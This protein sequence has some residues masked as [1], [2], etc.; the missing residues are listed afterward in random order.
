ML[1]CLLRFCHIKCQFFILI[2]FYASSQRQ[3]ILPHII[4]PLLT[5][6]FSQSIAKYLYLFLSETF[7]ILNFIIVSSCPTEMTSLGNGDT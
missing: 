6:V 4:L 2:I 7:Y 5:Y 3:V 1:C